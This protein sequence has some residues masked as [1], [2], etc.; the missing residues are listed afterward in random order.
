M[1]PRLKLFEWSDGFHIFT[2][3]A[4]SRPKALIAWG[5]DQDLFATGLAKEVHDSPDAEAAKASPGTVIERRL[6][7]KLPAGA[8]K[9]G[10]AKKTKKPSVADRKRVEEAQLALDDLDIMHG[11]ASRR[12]DEELQALRAR[13]DEERTAYQAQREKLQARLETARAKL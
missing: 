13:R 7:V 1:A 2:V 11:Q 9:K 5:S 3:A 10:S 6:D 12:A 4:S 8:G